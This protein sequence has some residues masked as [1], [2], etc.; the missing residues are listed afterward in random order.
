MKLLFSLTYYHPHISGL[1]IYVERLAVALAARGHEVTVLTSQHRPEL[2]REERRDGVRI[3]R[4]PVAFRISK[5]TIMPSYFKH[6]LPLLRAHDIL[7]LNLPGTPVESAMLAACA[8][9]VVP[10]P[11]LAGYYCD[12]RLPA[13]WFNRIVD[14]VVFLSNVVAGRLVARVVAMTADYAEHSRFLR[15]FTGKLEVIQPSVRVDT[16]ARD[17]VL[18]FRARHAPDGERLVGFAARFA[19][20]KGV[21]YL[22]DALPR[23]Q[24]AFPGVKILFTGDAASVIGEARYWQRMQ[25]LVSRAGAACVFLGALDRQELAAFYAACDVTVLPSLNS[26]ES[27]G[28]VQL[29]SMLCGTPVVASN[30]PGVRVPVR[31]TGMGL[32]VPPRDSNALAEAIVEVINNRTRYVRTRAE[33][34][35]HFSFETTVREYEM[36]F[37]RLLRDGQTGDVGGG[38][39]GS[40]E[41]KH[42]N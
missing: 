29:E 16:P 20:E 23:V 7:V 22:L 26:T 40:V 18:S 5:G 34:E 11:S 37:E 19:S 25:P 12:V 10:R 8:R 14:E 36:L 1:T 4:V 35:S 15:R 32:V 3:V 38:D 31:T 24:V 30:L 6:A 42:Q 28:L 27:F 39:G 33:I 2:P 21:E 13:G 41:P 9:F 17:D